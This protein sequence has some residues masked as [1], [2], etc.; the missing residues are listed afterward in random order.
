M[1]DSSDDVLEPCDVVPRCPICGIS[2]M[3][4]APRMER[5]TV[6]ICMSCDTSL[7]VPNEA[8]QLYQRRRS[9]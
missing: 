9:A 8:L 7:S 1:A 2:P 4:L 5:M 3:R 6:C